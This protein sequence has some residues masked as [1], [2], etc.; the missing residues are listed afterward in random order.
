MGLFTPKVPKQKQKEEAEFEKFLA[1]QGF[2]VS[3]KIT[4]SPSIYVDDVHKLFAFS[5]KQKI[6]KYSDLIDVQNESHTSIISTPGKGSAGKAIVGGLTF[7]VTGAVVGAS[8]KKAPQQHTI[9]YNEL[10]ILLNDLNTPMIIFEYASGT[11]VNNERLVL[12]DDAKA[13]LEGTFAY[14]KSNA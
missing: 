1:S 9:D 3:K 13:A 10:H 6:Y 11:Y 12:L 5:D 8:M 14:I 7:G 2:T 4:Q